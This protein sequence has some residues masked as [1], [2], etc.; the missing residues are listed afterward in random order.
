LGTGDWG[1]GIGDW[2][3][4]AGDWGLGIGDWGLEAGDWG[5]GIGDWGDV[6]L[7]SRRVEDEEDFKLS[8]LGDKHPEI[9]LS[10]K[11]VS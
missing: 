6:A 11:S 9:K 1:L 8:R 5:L 3:L 10:V 2:G 4:E 7:A